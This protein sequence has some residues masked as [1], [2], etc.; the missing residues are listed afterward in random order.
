MLAEARLFQRIGDDARKYRFKIQ[1]LPKDQYRHQ[2]DD[3]VLKS[4]RKENSHGK[5]FDAG[6]RKIYVPSM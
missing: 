5:D 2:N 1:R 6:K 4:E 3:G